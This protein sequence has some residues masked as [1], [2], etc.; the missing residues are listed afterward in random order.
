MKYPKSSLSI[1]VWAIAACGYAVSCT[2]D[3]PPDPERLGP[4]AGSP[5]DSMPGNNPPLDGPG[6]G[7]GSGSGSGTTP[8]VCA[9]KEHLENGNCVSNVRACA[10]AHGAGEQTWNGTKFGTCVL[11]SCNAGFQ[12]TANDCTVSFVGK[13]K[14]PCGLEPSDG[15]DEIWI[16]DFKDNVNHEL[17]GEVYGSADGK[18]LGVLHRTVRFVGTYKR[19]SVSTIETDAVNIDFNNPTLEITLHS[20]QA[21][22]DSNASKECGKSDWAINTPYTFPRSACT[23]NPSLVRTINKVEG[24]MLFVGNFQGEKDAS[25]RPK[26]LNREPTRVGHR[27]P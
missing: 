6:S 18:C 14:T 26:T 20:S 9:A 2:G 22:A 21:V 12:K 13:F 25:G 11:K 17:I 10:I 24:D 15:L 23:S 7:S 27:I 4:D 8:K 19:I 5:T 3:P 1:V 16:N